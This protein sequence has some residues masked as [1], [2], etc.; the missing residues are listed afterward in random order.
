MLHE[1]VKTQIWLKCGLKRKHNYWSCA[2][3]GRVGFFIWIWLDKWLNADLFIYL[4]LQFPTDGTSS[5]PKS[6]LMRFIKLIPSSRKHI[7]DQHDI[8]HCGNVALK[9]IC[10]FIW[11][12]NDGEKIVKLQMSAASDRWMLMEGLC[13]DV[14]VDKY[15]KSQDDVEALSCSLSTL[16]LLL[17]VFYVHFGLFTFHRPKV[18]YLLYQTPSWHLL[19]FVHWK[20]KN[21]EEFIRD[22][23]VIV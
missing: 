5:E 18:F 2:L 10:L 9:L 11:L 21:V 12:K 14:F 3:Y 4:F 20:R 23:S 7:R 13:T 1:G 8:N 22:K 15:F 17:W 6:R 19:Y 16:T